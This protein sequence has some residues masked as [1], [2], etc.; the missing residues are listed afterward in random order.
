MCDLC[1]MSM[2]PP[3]CP[4]FEG[5]LGGWAPV[6]GRCALCESALHGGE[7]VLVKGGD[8]LCEACADVAEVQ[9]VL[10][11]EGVGNVWELLCERL[12]WH[13]RVY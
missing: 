5:A 7:R 6:I 9:D 13:P 3:T 2:C 10:T 12:G 4:S 1:G 11:L 8:L